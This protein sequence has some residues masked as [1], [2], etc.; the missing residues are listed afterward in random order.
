MLGLREHRS[1]FCLQMSLDNEDKRARTRSKAVRGE[2]PLRWLWPGVPGLKAV[3]ATLLRRTEPLMSRLGRSSQ[4]A[5]HLGSVVSGGLGPLQPQVPEASALGSRQAC[6]GWQQETDG[7]T[8]WGRQSSVGRSFYL[9]SECCEP[10]APS[11][12]P[13]QHAGRSG[14]GGQ[15]AKAP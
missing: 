14:V 6:L 11:L 7:S 8:E 5:G 2:C 9:E 1:C 4:C 13:S 3:H 15:G 12:L 10:S